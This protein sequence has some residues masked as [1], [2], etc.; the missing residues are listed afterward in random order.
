MERNVRIRKHLSAALV[1]AFPVV[2]AVWM[3]IL[4]PEY[5][6]KLLSFNLP[7]AAVVSFFLSLGLCYGT[8]LL[9]A[10]TVIGLSREPTS[11]GKYG[12]G[13]FKFALLSAGLFIFLSLAVVLALT[14]PAL[15]ILLDSPVGK[16][17]FG[18]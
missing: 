14:S 3:G 7:A 18:G 17:F 5:F 15:L 2:I 16:M 10:N 12:A 13:L 8:V 9:I 4:S 6:A 1:T 11:A